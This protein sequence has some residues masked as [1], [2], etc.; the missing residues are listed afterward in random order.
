MS[1]SW[2]VLYPMASEVG[3]RSY[4]NSNSPKKGK[5]RFLTQG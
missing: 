1:L 5:S 4:S 2:V 3:G